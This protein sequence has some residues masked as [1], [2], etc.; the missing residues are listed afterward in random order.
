M[1]QSPKK[2][3][4]IKSTAVICAVLMLFTV[5]STATIPVGALSQQEAGQD[6][7]MQEDKAVKYGTGDAGQ[8]LAEASTD[9]PT[10]PATS[11][12]TEGSSKQ[13]VSPM[14]L[15]V[16]ADEAVSAA[17][18]YGDI[19]SDGRVNTV[20]VV[21]L[22]NAIAKI[23][24]L[25]TAQKALGDVNL[26]GVINSC[27]NIIIQMYVA[28]I[29]PYL[30]FTGKIETIP[31]SI[32]ITNA[33]KRMSVG[34]TQTL[35]YEITPNNAVTTLSWYSS[36]S[37]VISV[38]N[39]TINA[40]STG[41]A[42]ITV[43]TSN[44]LRSSV[45]ITV[46]K[47]PTSISLNPTTAKIGVGESIHLYPSVPSDC[48]ED[49]YKYSSTNTF[50]ATVN[51]KG[52]VVGNRTGTATIWAK[53]S[54]GK[55]TSCV[56]TVYPAPT[57][58]N[59][60][61]NTLT[62]GVD[63]SYTMIKTLS[64]GSYANCSL[65][66]SSNKKV[67]TVDLLSG[68]ITT[69]GVG[70][71][72][73]TVRT[74]NGLTATCVLTVKK[75]PTAVTT[76]KSSLSLKVNEAYTL[77]PVYPSDCYAWYYY[78]ESSNNSIA[79]VDKWSGA[80]TAKAKGTATIT[81]KT[82]NG[83]SGA[84]T[85]TVTADEISSIK[86]SS[87]ASSIMVGNHAYITAA[88]TPKGK[89]IAWSSSNTGVATVS[90]GIVKGVGTGS[91]TITAYDPIGSA[92]ASYTIN[93]T[94]ANSSG[95]SITYN[96]CTVTAG[97]TL[98]MKSNMG[99]SW[100]SSNTS[101]ATVNASGFIAAKS[102]GVA[103]ITMS[104]GGYKRTC[105]LTVTAA[106]PVR[107]A[108]TSPNTASKGDTITFVA[109][110]D[111]SRTGVQFKSTI[112]GSL[113]TIDATTKATD[114]TGNNYVWKGT[115]KVNYAGEFPVKTY[116]RKD[117]VWTTCDD[118]DTSIFVTNTTSSATA[119]FDKRRPSEEILSLNANYEGY[120]PSVTDD[121]LVADT[122]T[123]GYGYVVYAGDKFYN[124]MSKE[125][126]F[127]F[128]V[129]TMNDSSY[130]TSVNNFMSTNNIKFNQQQFDALVMMVYNIGAGVLND[131][132]VKS[133]LLNCVEST[134]NS[135]S[136]TAYVNASDGL[137]LRSGPGTDYYSYGIMAYGTSVTILEK[138]TSTWYKVQSSGG[139]IGY[140]S[141]DYLTFAS[142]SVRNMNYV[143]K[144]ALKSELIQWHHAGGGCVWGLLYRRIDEL[145]V[146]CYGDY[147]RDGS[148][149]KYNMSYRWDCY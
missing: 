1:N 109:I 141:K 140:C 69:V 23:V 56:V 90:N 107:F 132:D 120:T 142:S 46:L 89:S 86:L 114:S 3:W 57:S 111:K 47:Q 15:D 53:T 43:E 101:V 63:E 28:K 135:S 145:E 115:L 30:P 40:R 44:N 4:Y 105:A 137:N 116:S 81:V 54:N 143:N 66:S 128:M 146:F 95:Y 102:E 134:G 29:I 98:Y 130:S 124:N 70:T 75:A 50:V 91:A 82:Y 16:S 7:S 76:N 112:N 108:Y 20:D 71:A 149:N 34:K 67:A 144:D 37:S 129:R 126:A 62:L 14:P 58:I 119:A 100:S 148:S 87:T 84:C 52:V 147:V 80:V 17:A 35:S 139:V 27:D 78:F 110:T 5:F 8:L 96:A 104:S 74:Y 131:S 133:I 42:T 31:K 99:G 49:T 121:V 85:V 118:G 39:G 32:N 33:P 26:D 83:K 65:F 19:N 9:I 25:T 18:M 127:A 22:Q 45:T 113:Y 72:N 97:K 6:Q 10:E 48:Y 13:A 79:T 21:I 11:Q 103:I 60:N 68:K 122:P 2:F 94:S 93:V 77:S 51:D 12:P 106:A 36:N 73:I 59:L 136:S 88:V 123:V 64:D 117:G 125:E 55:A 24:T 61:R 92:K 41:T 138:T 38:N